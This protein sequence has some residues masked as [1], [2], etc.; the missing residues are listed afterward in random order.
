ML[1]HWAILQRDV[2]ESA[3]VTGDR[4]VIVDEL[5]FS[6]ALQESGYTIEVFQQG[7]TLDVVAAQTQ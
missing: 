7:K 5:P 3:A 1:F 2:P 4:G 6:Q